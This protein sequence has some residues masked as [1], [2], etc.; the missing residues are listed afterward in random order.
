M[1][2]PGFV[3]EASLLTVT[4]FRTSDV[5]LANFSTG[6]PARRT[7]IVPQQARLGLERHRL[8]MSRCGQRCLDD[9]TKARLECAGRCDKFVGRWSSHFRGCISSC[10]QGVDVY[11]GNK[12]LRGAAALQPGYC[13]R[14]CLL[15]GLDRLPPI[16][17]QP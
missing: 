4:R 9:Q 7:A 3:A 6:S 17:T 10:Q 13:E 14:S 15:P 11:V 12:V 8:F 5:H 2:L 1:S 16:F